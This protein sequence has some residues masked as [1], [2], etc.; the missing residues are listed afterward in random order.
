MIHQLSENILFI[1]LFFKGI[2]KKDKNDNIQITT[3]V[4]NKKTSLSSS[5]SESKS[6]AEK[7]ISDQKVEK[8]EKGTSSSG[9][10]SALDKKKNLFES[11]SAKDKISRFERPTSKGTS[12]PDRAESPSK[13][14]SSSPLPSSLRSDST[15]K[16]AS[17]F[18]RSESDQSSDSSRSSS[19]T[20]VSTA[21][22]YQRSESGQS[23][24]SSSTDSPSQIR[25]TSVKLGE[26]KSATASPKSTRTKNTSGGS[27]A[28]K[29]A[30]FN[31]NAANETSTGRFSPKPS[32]VKVEKKTI[33]V[34]PVAKEKKEREVKAETKS[35]PKS[36]PH[37]SKTDVTATMTKTDD[38]P[39]VTAAAEKVNKS[40]STEA[41]S[42][43]TTPAS[44][45][46]EKLSNI[47]RVKNEEA[48]R[49][50]PTNRSATNSPAASKK[51]VT[52]DSLEKK[53]AASAS[54]T[55]IKKGGA[56]AGITLS[57]N[58]GGSV[59][60][61]GKKLHVGPLQSKKSPAAADEQKS[62]TVTP[63]TPTKDGDSEETKV[64]IS[65]DKKN[66]SIKVKLGVGRANWQRNQPNSKK[67]ENGTVE[68]DETAD[69]SQDKTPKLKELRGKSQSF[70]RRARSN[71][72]E[73]G[74]S[75]NSPR[76]NYRRLYVT[77]VRNS[78]VFDADFNLDSEATKIMQRVD[79]DVL[80]VELRLKSTDLKLL[81]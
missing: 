71:T 23:T 49:S 39:T 74:S 63:P 1:F 34:T 10:R 64:A 65:S 52:K 28:E 80:Q 75:P 46:E 57:M 40:K 16:L 78:R 47:K 37:S 62:L 22:K 13:F 56:A 31:Q 5:P 53:P 50:S 68:Y 9:E 70:S 67:N 41:T 11:G 20:K 33:P 4:D 17:K 36:S 7:V 25:K 77:K 42:K 6:K 45:S 69:E 58:I 8:K 27:I 54:P 55:V 59:S 12:I 19:P 2:I 14:R 26:S 21:T 35:S 72:Q 66:G 24:G 18:E 61:S 30:K 73:G 43:T 60:S 44:K 38:S 81:P 48:G 15:S 76:K 79:K 3:P 29:M 32:V 51:I